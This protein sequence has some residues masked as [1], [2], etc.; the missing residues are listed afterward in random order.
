MHYFR[1][2][3]TPRRF[4]LRPILELIEKLQ[5]TGPTYTVVHYGIDSYVGSSANSLKSLYVGIRKG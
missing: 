2:P 5:G 3:C 4:T 1:E